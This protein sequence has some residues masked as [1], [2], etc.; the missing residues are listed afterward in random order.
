[1]AHTGPT[2][3]LPDLTGRRAV[4]T[5]A[6][7]GIGL[8]IAR[9]LAGAGAEVLLP[10]RNAAKGAAAIATIREHHPEA[11]LALHELDLSSLDSVE[12]FAATLEAEAA[13]IHL[14]INNAGVMTP[15]D[16]RTTADGFELQFGTNHLG[17]VALTARL[18]PLL[19]EGRARVTSQTSVAAR[20][21]EI[22]WNDPNSERDYDGM[23][24]YS[25]SKIAFGLFALELDRRSRAAGW[26]ITSTLSH[27]GVAPTSLLASRPEMGRTSDTVG[28]R[29]IRVLSRLGVLAGTAESA[30]LPA[31]LAATIPNP[32]TSPPV[33]FGPRGIGHTAGGPGT[34]RLWSPLT[35]AEDAERV[36]ALATELTGVAWPD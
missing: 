17:H 20:R 18:L 9:H 12:A 35:D 13:P 28:V 16:R 15:P 29:V 23:S 21:G 14:L 30:A 10:A 25:Q 8:I 7:D 2:I 11:R 32:P 34:H 19:R 26:G 33:L 4:V 27:P 1:M 24:A 3:E 6:T 22:A 5:G 31:L 36:W